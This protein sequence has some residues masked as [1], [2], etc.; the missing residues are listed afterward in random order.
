MKFTVPGAGRTVAF[1]FDGRLTGAFRSAGED[2][3]SLIRDALHRNPDGERLGGALEARTFRGVLLDRSIHPFEDHR[4]SGFLGV[5]RAVFEVRDP[6]LRRILLQVGLVHL[7]RHEAMPERGADGLD[8]EKTLMKKDAGL[9]L[10]LLTDHKRK[11]FFLPRIL[12]EVDALVAPESGFRDV[13]APILTRLPFV[14][15]EDPA[16]SPVGIPFLNGTA[17]DRLP[18]YER[19]RLIA[20]GVL[21]WYTV[22]SLGILSPLAFAFRRVSPY[23]DPAHQMLR[24]SFKEGFLLK[25]GFMG[26][27]VRAFFRGN[28]PEA[29]E[30]FW[31][32]WNPVL[33]RVAVRPVYRF[34]GGNRSPIFA[35]TVTFFYTAWIVHLLW[36][37]GLV[38]LGM[39]VASLADPG[40]TAGA[41]IGSNAHFAVLLGAVGAYTFFGL[42]S[43]LSKALRARRKR[44]GG[45]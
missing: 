24:H 44:K 22:L 14:Q 40:F 1:E 35:T 25:R 23:F 38:L 13:L 9:F 16:D 11:V 4:R 39:R 36:A 30:F 32:G 2:P 26:R 18:R 10:L 8:L 17:F 7:L 43:G 6:V 15:K 45:L 29:V 41:R 42:L 34:F 28:F 37:A 21:A 33:V 20:G 3:A 5:N 19:L 12:R 27:A 31:S